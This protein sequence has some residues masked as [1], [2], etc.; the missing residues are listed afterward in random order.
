MIVV[1]TKPTAGRNA[2]E[3]P[4]NS[5]QQREPWLR[6]AGVLLHIGPP[7]TGTT[8]I[9]FGLAEARAD[10]ARCGILYPDTGL[11]QGAAALAL[12]QRHSSWRRVIHG[13][14][15]LDPTIDQSP[16]LDLVA[17]AGEWNGK[18]VISSEYLAS[19][20]PHIARQAVTDLGGS[21]VQILITRRPAIQLAASQWQQGVKAGN[22]EPWGDWLAASLNSDNDAAM[23][24]VEHLISRWI[25]IVGANNIAV[26]NVSPA[27]PREILRELERVIG[28]PAGLL[29]LGQSNRSMTAYE[30]E[31]VRRVWTQVDDEA[32]DLPNFLKHVRRG[33]RNLVETRTPAAHEPK[34]TVPD[35][36]VE[37]LQQIDFE[38]E[39]AVRSLGVTVF[40]DPFQNQPNKRTANSA[41]ST[42]DDE[43]TDDY[44]QAAA[45]VTYAFLAESSR[46]TAK[47]Q[48]KLKRL[49]AKRRAD[50]V[51]D[52]QR[53][54][55]DPHPA[56]RIQRLLFRRSQQK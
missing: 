23:L 40:G 5:V 18:V 17:A 2:A 39:S 1:A 28:I 14:S 52:D 25:D 51:T 35:W 47:S 11:A 12:Q 21:R 37:P 55:P 29:P 49:R 53:K 20:L 42:L 24:R 10:L 6:E 36:A 26:I 48:R 19:S 4:R 9:Q 44:L 50:K 38:T 54:S 56:A 8:A 46:A 15:L 13:E 32:V 33:I 45:E 31:I 41:G 27:D 30:A 16:W 22:T 7:K 43:V 34:L 3:L